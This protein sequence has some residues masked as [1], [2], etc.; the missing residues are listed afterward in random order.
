M[1][2]RYFE[3]NRAHLFWNHY[4]QSAHNIDKPKWCKI[5]IQGRDSYCFPTYYEYSNRSTILHRF[6]NLQLR[7][8][9]IYRWKWR[10]YF[11]RGAKSKHIWNSEWLAREWINSNY[12]LRS[13]NTRGIRDP[14]IVRF[15]NHDCSLD[16]CALYV[17]LMDA[18][19]RLLEINFISGNH[20]EKKSAAHWNYV[21]IQVYQYLIQ[22]GHWMCYMSRSVLK[23]SRSC[24]AEMQQ[25]PH[26]PYWMHRVTSEIPFRKQLEVSS[27]QIVN[28]VSARS[29]I[30]MI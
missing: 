23:G 1:D 6:R 29:Y 19:R 27:V 7:I 2:C 24:S 16:L 14:P 3:L 18:I 9:H 17:V 25:I 22:G 26:F 13:F 21:Q 5:C 10:R 28:W 11:W 12:L 4:F 30:S 8:W 20:E 15:N